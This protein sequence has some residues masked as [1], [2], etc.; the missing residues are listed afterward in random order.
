MT[1]SIAQFFLRFLSKHVQIKDEDWEIYG[2]GIEAFLHTVF[3]IGGLVLVSFL[4]QKPIEG[5]IIIIL[6]H[7]NQTIGG[8]FH[9]TTHFRCF[10]LM[11]VF[12]L[13]SLLILLL[14]IAPAVLSAVTLLSAGFLFFI[15]L[16]LHA[17]KAYL[18]DRSAYFIRRSRI[19]TA[20]ELAVAIGMMFL[21]EF[22][23]QCAFGLG[24]AV[25]AL[26]RGAGALASYASPH[27][28]R[29]G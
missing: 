3:T 17:N 15:P 16:V 5:V 9:A 28:T 11:A 26:S 20:V 2:Y 13:I 7:V 6:Y 14:P 19:I 24:M 25:S 1:R 27:E 4:M 21:C 10:L 18:A 12:L 22:P 29:K 8:G 23:I